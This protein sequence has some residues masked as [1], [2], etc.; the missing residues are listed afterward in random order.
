M[1]L[2]VSNFKE[3]FSEIHLSFMETSSGECYSVILS[4]S[5]VIII[6]ENRI[7]FNGE[8][9]ISGSRKEKG[10]IEFD[11]STITFHRVKQTKGKLYRFKEIELD[12]NSQ[13][14][15]NNVLELF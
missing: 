15:F 10:S 3:S 8:L 9:T 11:L 6:D 7:V 1:N 2:I 14:E 5:E 12:P 4:V 13:S